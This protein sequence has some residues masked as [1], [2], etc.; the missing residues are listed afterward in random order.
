MAALR[1]NRSHIQAYR[2]KFVLHTD[3]LVWDL[4]LVMATT[5]VACSHM[6]ERWMRRGGTAVVQ[7]VRGYSA[8]PTAPL[9]PPPYPGAP[10]PLLPSLTVRARRSYKSHRAAAVHSSPGDSSRCSPC[11]VPNTSVLDVYIASMWCYKAQ[12]RSYT[13][14]GLSQACPPGTMLKHAPSVTNFAWY[15]LP[16]CRRFDLV[17]KSPCIQLAVH[18]HVLVYQAQVLFVDNYT[19]FGFIQWNHGTH[20]H[21]A[22]GMLKEGGLACR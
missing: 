13:K 12:L 15:R 22:H 7:T 4:P 16:S 18:L 6:A 2:H 5:R 14:A 11:A 17:T 19:E 1:R 3:V 10:S 9:T 8:A 21:T 20:M